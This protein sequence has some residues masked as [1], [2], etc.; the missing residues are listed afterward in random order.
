M[1]QH[2]YRPKSRLIR[3]FIEHG[4]KEGLAAGREEGREEG[5]ESATA[6]DAA[7]VFDVE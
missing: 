5:R 2:G 1:Q 4:R 6:V 3:L 7:D